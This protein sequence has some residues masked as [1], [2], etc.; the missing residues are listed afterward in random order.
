MMTKITIRI[1]EEIARQAKVLAAKRG[2]SLSQ[3]VAKQLQDMLKADL[4]FD[5]AAA[6]R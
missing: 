3:L 1:D 5:R 4:R 6:E 2:T